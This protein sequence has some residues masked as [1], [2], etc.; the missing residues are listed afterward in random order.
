VYV[1]LGKLWRCGKGGW[2]WF[3]MRLSCGELCIVILLMV[4]EEVF[5]MDRERGVAFGIITIG[6]GGEKMMF[7]RERFGQYLE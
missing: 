1:I 6:G 4:I 3:G 2:Y 5:R 7:K